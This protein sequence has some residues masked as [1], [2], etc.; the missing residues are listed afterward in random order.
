MTSFNRPT[1]ELQTND[2]PELVIR[3]S[4]SQELLF[5]GLYTTGLPAEY[6]EAHKLLFLADQKLQ[7][8]ISK[9]GGESY[10]F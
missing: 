10:E 3:L 6:Y 8:M 9:S 7:Q 5:D 1:R 2:I 4:I